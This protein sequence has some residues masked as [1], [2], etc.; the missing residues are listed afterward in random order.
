MLL[1][2]LDFDRYQPRTYIIGEGDILSA[3]KAARLEAVKAADS[4][5]T[6]SV[7]RDS[8]DSTHKHSQSV[9]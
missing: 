8:S 9:L 3:K 4:D 6:R 2:S 7:V 5:S 1:S